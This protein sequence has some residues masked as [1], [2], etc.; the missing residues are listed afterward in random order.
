MDLVTAF[1]SVGPCLGLPQT[2]ES[3]SRRATAA[4]VVYSRLH[5]L[6]RRL[7]VPPEMAEDAASD[8]CAGLIRNGPR[9]LPSCPET[10]Q[11]VDAYLAVCLRNRVRDA[12]RK[13][14]RTKTMEEDVEDPASRAEPWAVTFAPRLAE[15][16]RRVVDVMDVLAARLGVER[17]AEFTRQMRYRTEI[18]GG[19]LTQDD[20]VRDAFGEVSVKTR[21]RFY[22]RQFRALQRLHDA[23][24]ERIRARREEGDSAEALRAVVRGLRDLR[25]WV[26]NPAE[27]E[28]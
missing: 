7:R 1:R 27:I 8:V 12:I 9:S 13:A 25:P 22:Q 6:A 16:H 17:G 2:A 15:A 11:G 3:D 23:V 28:P 18:A 20:C 10:E 14:R 24:E 21:N 26:A 4:A 5:A 19:R